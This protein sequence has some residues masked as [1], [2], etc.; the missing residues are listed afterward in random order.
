MLFTSIVLLAII[1]A[2]IIDVYNS[3]KDY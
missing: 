2:F 1:L 3:G